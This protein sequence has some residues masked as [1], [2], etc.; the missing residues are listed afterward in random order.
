[1]SIG[2]IKNWSGRRGKAGAVLAVLLAARVLAA[3]EV[4]VANRAA[5][6]QDSAS[7]VPE[8]AQTASA[9]HAMPQVE[10]GKV[11]QREVKASLTEEVDEWTKATDKTQWLGYAVP[12]VSSERRTCCGNYGGDWNSESC[13]PCRLE[14]AGNGNNYNLRRGDVKLEGPANLLVLLRAEHRKIARV[15]AVS[16]DCTLDA[17]GLQVTWLTGV[18]PAESV[19]LLVARGEAFPTDDPARFRRAPASAQRR[20][21]R[22]VAGTS[23]VAAASISAPDSSR[24]PVGVNRSIRSVTTEERPDRIDLKKSPSGTRPL[25]R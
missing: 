11:A 3:S 4:T 19:R 9:A 5:P 7:A 24:I 12:A 16:D 6:A 22:L 2:P 25:F 1:M 13:G 14:S 10:N 23:R 8:K 18:K 21:S 17:A 15:R 20:V